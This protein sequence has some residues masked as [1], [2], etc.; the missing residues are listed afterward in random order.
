MKKLS[1]VLLVVLAFSAGTMIGSYLHQ[2]FSVN[3][4]YNTTYQISDQGFSL[5]EPRING[6]TVYLI[7]ECYVV[8]FDV[9]EDQAYSIQ[10]GIEKS[11][12]SRPLTHDIMKDILDVFDVQILK[13][14]I[15]R[16]E[17]K[18]YFAT[19]FLQSAEKVLELD[20][21][22]SDSIAIS[23]RT[24]TPIYFKSSILQTTGE[25]IC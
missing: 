20:T 6:T 11:F 19:I 15:D 23:L 9:T 2:P 3:Y 14:R 1:V 16:Y 12:G 5:V 17:D 7:G 21:R 18:V 25:Y 22:P 13:V 4:F 10:R 8:S 24:Q